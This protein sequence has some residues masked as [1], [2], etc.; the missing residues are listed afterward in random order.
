MCPINV[1]KHLLTPS[2]NI[3]PFFGPL[4]LFYHRGH[5]YSIHLMSLAHRLKIK[6]LIARCTYETIQ[7]AMDITLT[8]GF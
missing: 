8:T 7:T 5:P 1:F 6:I 2:R 4:Q 3:E